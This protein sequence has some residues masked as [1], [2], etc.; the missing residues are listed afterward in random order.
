MVAADECRNLVSIAEFLG[1]APQ[2]IFYLVE[3]PERYYTSIRIPKNSDPSKFRE[4]NIPLSE[5]KGVQRAIN[6]KILSQYSADACVHSYV[7]ARSI[8][9]AAREFCPGKAVLKIDIKDFFPAITFNRVLGLFKFIGF[10]DASS[11][12]LARLTTF[13]NH[14]AQGAP[15]SPSISNFIAWRMDSRLKKLAETWEML[16]LRYS[17]DMFFYKERNFNHPK[18]YNYAANIIESSGFVVNGD[19]TRFYPK[20][21]PRITLGL[22]THLDF[23]KI[24]G[25]QRRIYRSLFFKASRNIHWAHQNQDQLRGVLEPDSKAYYRASLLM[26]SWIEARVTK[27]RRV[28][29]RFSQSLARRRL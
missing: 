21:L 18:F 23:P 3:N 9:T 29:A 27:A 14:L 17:D 25:T 11:F 8:L 13:D 20:G 24:P 5:L 16:Y 6:K 28:S 15:T 2:H 7:G 10:S 19:K 12:I 4:L 22:L 1:F 26:A